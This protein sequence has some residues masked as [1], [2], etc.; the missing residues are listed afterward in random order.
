MKM[1]ERA[2]YREFQGQI[3]P[4]RVLI[5]LGASGLI[6]KINLLYTFYFIKKNTFLIV[7]NDKI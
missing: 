2:I 3:N 4:G 7:L 5:L 1:I 6:G